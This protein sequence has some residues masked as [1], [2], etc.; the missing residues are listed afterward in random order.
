MALHFVSL[1]VTSN[2]VHLLSHAAWL[3]CADD[4][5][6]GLTTLD[7]HWSSGL[8][9]LHAYPWS[10]QEVYEIGQHASRVGSFAHSS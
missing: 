5:R 6:K 7:L 8:A 9:S 1:R 2:V 10:L 4:G 3:D